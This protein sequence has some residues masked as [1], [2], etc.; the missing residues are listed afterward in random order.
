MTDV[1]SAPAPLL[2]PAPPS[3]PALPAPLTPRRRPRLA[4]CPTLP[5]YRGPLAVPPPLAGGGVDQPGGRAH[6]RSPLRWDC[7]ARSR[8]ANNYW[9]GLRRCS[10][11]TAWPATTRIWPCCGT[12]RAP[13][14]G[15]GSTTGYPPTAIPESRPISRPPR[16]RRA[17]HRADR[18]GA[19]RD[20]RLRPPRSRRWIRS[21]AADPGDRRYRVHRRWDRP[22]AR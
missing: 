5:R 9:T 14:G 4:A 10:P 21:S 3:T 16:H 17:R 12:R 13:S 2:A 6:R 15:S 20:R 19:G 18:V 11:M 1:I 7:S 8:L 22:A